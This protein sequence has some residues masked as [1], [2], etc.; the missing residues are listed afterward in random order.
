MPAWLRT[1]EPAR[2][3]AGVGPP[4]PGWAF[5]SARWRE[6]QAHRRWAD[7]GRAWLAERGQRAAWWSLTRHRAVAR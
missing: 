6:I 5:G 7:A 2:W 3:S 1:F 4:P